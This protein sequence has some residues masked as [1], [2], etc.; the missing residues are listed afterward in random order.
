MLFDCIDV[1]NCFSIDYM[2]NVPLGIFKDMMTI[3]LGMKRI[4]EHACGISKIKSVESRKMF[5]KRVMSLKPPMTFCRKPR[6]IF[7]VSTFKASELLYCMFYYVRYALIGL[8]PTRVIKNFEKLYSAIYTLCK[9]TIKIDEIHDACK[10]LTEFAD[11]F[12]EIYG[13]GAVTLNLHLL[14]HYF[15]MIM[16]CGPLWAYSLFGFENNIGQLKEYV[17]GTTDV[18]DQIT[19]KY[20]IDRIDCEEPNVPSDQ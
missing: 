7:D 3:W 1:I 14:R 2:H 16:N 11:E 19:H 18:L 8:L 9:K 17:V 6:S 4:P 12:Q 10:L 15:E 5:N 20:S 13:P